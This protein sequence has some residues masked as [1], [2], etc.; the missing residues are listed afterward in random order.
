MKIWTTIGAA[1]AALGLLAASAQA[2]T[3]SK[4][5]N[6]FPG[7]NGIMFDITAGAQDLTIQSLTAYFGPGD[8]DLEFYTIAGGVAGHEN[9]S[10]GWTLRNTIDF[11]AFGFQSAEINWDVADFDL[12]AGQTIGLYITATADSFG[13]IWYS[14]SAVPYGA[15]IATDGLLSLRSGHASPYLFG[16]GFDGRNFNGSITYRIAAVPEPASWALMILGFGGAGAALRRR[17]AATARLA[18]CACG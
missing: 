16:P 5:L 18:P 12:A 4:P 7:Q 13:R 17:R 6:G 8:L 9:S 1:T 15:V 14:N 11:A 2:A 3:L 10:A